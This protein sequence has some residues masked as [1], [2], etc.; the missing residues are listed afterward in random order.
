MIVHGRIVENQ[1]NVSVY[2]LTCAGKALRFVGNSG[3][4][5]PR[6]QSHVTT[7]LVEQRTIKE[8]LQAATVHYSPQIFKRLSRAHDLNDEEQDHCNSVETLA[9]LCTGQLQGI[10]TVAS[11]ML[12][13]N[14]EVQM[15]LATK[16]MRRT[17]LRGHHQQMQNNKGR[18]TRV[19]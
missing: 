19:W 17:L 8:V 15:D 16:H 2:M 4:A 12:A 10:G 7:L 3:F 18:R 6:S 14:A 9:G 11:E 13:F 5:L 1:R